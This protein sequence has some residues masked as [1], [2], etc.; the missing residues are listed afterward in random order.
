[1]KTVLNKLL[2]IFII[3]MCGMTNVYAFKV[4]THV[5]IGQQ[6]IND[7]SD[8]YL[9][10]E[11]NG[12]LYNVPVNSNVKEAITNNPSFYRMGNIGP[13][14]VPDIIVGQLVVHPG[15][16]NSW[17]TDD[18]L[19]YLLNSPNI[20]PEELAFIYGYLGHAAADMW[21]HTFVNMYSGNV[22]RLDDGYAEEE[23][24]IEIEKFIATFDPPI[25]DVSGTF[26][27]KP[28]NLLSVPDVFLRDRLVLNDEVAQKNKE[29][30]AT[31][32]ALVQDL[33]SAL[34]GL[35]DKELRDLDII[36]MKFF[37]YNYTG[38]W[39][40]DEEAGDLVDIASSV[41]KFVT[42]NDGSEE[43][44]EAINLFLNTISK[45]ISTASDLNN[46]VMSQKQ[47]IED[48]LI[49]INN[50]R[51][52]IEGGVKEYIEVLVSST[53]RKAC[54]FDI[55]GRITGW[56]EYACNV[57]ELQRN[58]LW[59]ELNNRINELENN[60]IPAARQVA[61][62]ATNLA[63]TAMMTD[64]GIQQAAVNG[65]IDTL[66]RITSDVNIV[67]ALR[68]GWRKDI[69]EAMR[70]YMHA[71]TELIT[72]SMNY[73]NSTS[74]LLKPIT[75][76]WDCY[77]SSM[78]GIPQPITKAGCEIKKYVED[79]NTA[80]DKVSDSVSGLAASADPT[81]VIEE[82]NKVKL[83]IN[84]EIK[85][86]GE[87]LVFAILEKLFEC[88]FEELLDAYSAEPTEARLHDMFSQDRSGSQTECMGGGKTK[89]GLII[90]NDM[91]AR[92]KAEMNLIGNQYNP[93]KF[94][95]MSNAITMVKLSLLD[96]N[97]LNDLVSQVTSTQTTLYK[98][99]NF[100]TSNILFGMLKNMDGNHQ[101]ME[102]APP[103]ARESGY[104]DIKWPAERDY[105][106][107]NGMPLWNNCAVRDQVFRK[108]FKGPVAQGFEQPSLI[109]FSEVAPA[110][111][112]VLGSS[113]QPFPD[114]Q[115]SMQCENSWF[116][117][118]IFSLLL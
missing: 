86:L 28:E 19:K 76:W 32:L 88:D 85:G 96:A 45:Y 78:V 22:F 62:D 51:E 91:P 103:Y 20:K 114:G 24:H 70:V 108:L 110:G 64:I 27:G 116:I 48:A 107:S 117:S 15:I 55:L 5:W 58:P 73:S 40:S 94:N 59:D 60:V 36:V 56:C 79:L 29:G 106:Y 74:Q 8:G 71:N 105:G 112:A 37:I 33:Y 82:V 46:K 101:W 89:K 9:T 65:A 84:T 54:G 111:L 38:E 1:M 12:Q 97:G 72:L 3:F 118:V 42:N 18:W 16:E 83:K 14:A 90:I 52:A 57:P 81:G 39:V 93:E 13:D 102:L 23:R 113:S 98:E 4:Q 53:C 68:D 11:V 95:V 115:W 50:K 41:H 67:R 10:F 77:G 30:G 7:V 80:L 87:D 69:E 99:N 26:L 61:T 104:T 49:E 2:P 43:T 63:I 44:Q 66:E 109:G 92:M 21:A 25:N 75:D 100:D 31:H 47:K 6:V 34:D 17:A 35:G